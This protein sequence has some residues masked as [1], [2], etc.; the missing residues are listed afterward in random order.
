[1]TFIKDLELGNKYEKDFVKDLRPEDYKIMNGK[2][3]EYDIEIYKYGKT[4]YYE[5]KSDRFTHK[6]GNFC[7]EYECNSNE[8]GI[9]STTSDY[10]VYYVIKPNNEHD[11]YVIPTR[12][13][14]RLIKKQE[15][16]KDI[17]GGD[18]YRSRFYLFDKDKFEEYLKVT[19]GCL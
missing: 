11:I 14:R 17:S 8:S 10:Y 13:I 5:V 16:K 6:T 15:Y 4:K 9:T 19:K 1:M 12:K 3:K 2:F 7:I 18:G